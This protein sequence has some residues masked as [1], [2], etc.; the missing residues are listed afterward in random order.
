MN[1]RP[2][3]IHSLLWRAGA[4][5]AALLAAMWVSS[6]CD[7]V[8]SPDTLIAATAYNF[9][10]TYTATAGVPGDPIVFGNSGPP[11]TMFQVVQ[12]G[13]HG[14]VSD[15]NRGH[16]S[17]SVD[18]GPT[19]EGASAFAQFVFDGTDGRGIR[20]TLVGSFNGAEGSQLTMDGQWL[21]PDT[22]ATAPFRGFA[23]AT[24]PFNTDGGTNTNGNANSNGVPQPPGS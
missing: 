12:T 8:G 19:G 11:V 21:E 24:Q 9:S 13:R 1:L 10:G 4:L 17:G 22:G 2:S 15:N 14:Q 16:Y 7:S 20:V 3:S 5:A 23:L 6:S 18:S